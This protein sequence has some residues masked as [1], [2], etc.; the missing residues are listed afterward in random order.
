MDA[1]LTIH[2]PGVVA[3]QRAQEP[4]A[5][6]ADSIAGEFSDEALVAQ[7]REGSREALGVLF[8]RYA[9]TV[10]GVAYRVLR[11]T[12]EADDLLQDIFL[13]IYR[14]CSM[15]DASRGPARFLDPAVDLSPRAGSP[16]ISEFPSLLYAAGP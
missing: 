14:K 10:R 1:S 9:R 2:F 6:P 12:S 15:F 5:G 8:R 16:P 11:N 7:L 13:L 3:D 4:P